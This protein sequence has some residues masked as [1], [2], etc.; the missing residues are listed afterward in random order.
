MLDQL[1]FSGRALLILS[2]AL[3]RNYLLPIFPSSTT[4]LI[5][6]SM[7]IRHLMAFGGLFFF[8]MIADEDILEASEIVPVIISCIFLYTWFLIASKMTANWWIPVVILLAGLYAMNIYRQNVSITKK[9][10]VYADYAEYITVALSGLLTLVGFIIYV[11]EKKIDYRGKFDYATLI[12]GTPTCKN[13]PSKVSY[14]DSLKAA[15]TAAPGTAMKG[16]FISE[17][18]ITPISSFDY[19]KAE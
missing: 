15:F 4:R 19:I 6:D 3:S 18:A 14:W 10:A 7:L 13:T 2:F 17:D 5:E 11:G 1:I 8:S 9:V 12:L 16:G